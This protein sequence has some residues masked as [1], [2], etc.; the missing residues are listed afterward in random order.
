MNHRNDNM[1]CCLLFVCALACALACPMGA[2]AQPGQAAL[3]WLDADFQ[4]V[5]LGNGLIYL[6][7]GPSPEELRA[8]APANIDAANTTNT[9]QLWTGGGLGLDLTGAG[10][11]VG[12][13]DGGEVLP[14]HQEF[15]AGQIT[16]NDSFEGLNGHATHVAGTIGAAG[17]DSEARGMAPDVAI[18]TW[19]FH[20]DIAEMTTAAPSLQVS[21]HSYGEVRGWHGWTWEYPDPP[22]GTYSGWTW[23]ADR[24]VYDT[25]DP[26]FGKYDDDAAALDQVLHD[27]PKLLSVW[28]AANERG[29]PGP[30]SGL[31]EYATYFS[32]PPS[33]GAPLD[34]AGW[35]VVPT[36]DYPAPP[37]DTVPDG[38]HDTL[39]GA[40]VAKNN[41]VVGSVN[42]IT[43]DPYSAGNITLAGYSSLG[44]ADDGR[45]KPD[46]VGNGQFLFSTSPSG[47][48]QYATKVG[49]SMASPNVAGTAALLYE[50]Y[51]DLHG[52]FPDSDT[53][54]AA[55]IHTA[56]DAG[57]PGPDYSFG[58]GLVDAAA[59]AEF[60]SNSA[61][62]GSTDHL[63]EG[64]YDGTEIITDIVS[65]GSS[66][67]KAS[68][69]WTDPAGT[70]QPAG[71][72]DPTPVLVND[73]DLWVTG[74]GGTYLPWTL[75]PSD[76]TA[77]AVQSA[78][79]HVDNVVQVLIDTVVAGAYQ[80]HI[81]HSGNSFVQDF[82]LLFSGAATDMLAVPE[83]SAWALLVFG[84]LLIG[85]R[86]R[87]RGG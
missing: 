62:T 69:V 63:V 37:Q 1:R 57:N 60:L 79:N 26:G 16:N 13:W 86:R 39:P 58:W 25:E 22:G 40:Q 49:T 50:H 80:I 41:L 33:P 24:A 11:N 8:L 52:S 31:T 2:L 56:A 47:D 54:K 4:P 48:D 19:D 20:D 55:L 73:L 36:S 70:P 35:Y 65:D 5:D 83:P 75:D 72:D 68:L 12:V 29:S 45:M 71:V 64:T 6:G 44:P 76:P 30:G 51:R 87:R 15:Y 32:S 17:V 42:D 14:T 74:P 61:M 21:N 67:L 28:A 10:V 78:L 59:A 81:G 43:V 38:G 3:P 23:F 7:P 18:Q 27:N 77:A 34:E 82:S 53:V 66:P 9:D 85:W 84:G 46:V